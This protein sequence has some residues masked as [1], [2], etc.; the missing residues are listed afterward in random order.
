[1]QATKL[2]F[3]SGV[4]L[5]RRTSSHWD[6]K[7][8]SRMR[9]GQM[10]QYEIE[11]DVFVWIP[12]RRARAWNALSGRIYISASSITFN[13]SSLFILADLCVSRSRTVQLTV[14][15]TDFIN[16]SVRAEPKVPNPWRAPNKY[17]IIYRPRESNRQSNEFLSL[18]SIRVRGM[19]P[20]LSSNTRLSRDKIESKHLLRAARKIESGGSV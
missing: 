19:R 18:V 9:P 13:K 20:R 4:S 6:N 7:M 3:Y 14:I 11:S 2:L 16:K 15:A 10:E 5:C 17:N 8:T 1:M 12:T